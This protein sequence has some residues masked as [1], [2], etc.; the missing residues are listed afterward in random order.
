MAASHHAEVIDLYGTLCTGSTC[1]YALNGN[2]LFEDPHHLT[3]LGAE[4][5]LGEAPASLVGEQAERVEISP[6]DSQTSS[7][8][9]A[10]EVKKSLPS[11]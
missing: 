10:A 3:R 6:H 8:D 2:P 4:F 7:A 9:T 1:R 5:A 11:L